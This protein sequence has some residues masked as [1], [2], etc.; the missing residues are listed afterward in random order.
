M[1]T[2]KENIYKEW[3]KNGQLHREDGPA[4]IYKN[5]DKMWCYNGKLHREDGPSV[6]WE[7]GTI[8][9]WY[10]YGQLAGDKKQF[11]DE[12]WRKEVLL[13]LV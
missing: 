13:D 6:E 5:G 12:K 11:Y 3:L 2:S 7:D 4:V 9:Y 8:K 10:Y 1:G